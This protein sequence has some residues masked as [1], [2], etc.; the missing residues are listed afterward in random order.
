MRVV[1]SNGFRAGALA[2]LGGLVPWF[3]WIAAHGEDLV[4]AAFGIWTDRAGSSWSVEASGNLSR[5]G[6]T[7]VNSGLALLIDE[8]K[9]VPQTPMMTPDGRELVIAGAPL[10]TVPGLRVQRRIRILDDP[11][12]LRY[13]ELF[14]NESADPIRLSVGLATSFSGN[15]KTFLSDRGRSE[16]LLMGPSETGVIVLPGTAQSSRAFLFTLADADAEGKA[17]ISSQNRYGLTFRYPLQLAPGES[18][19]LVHHVAQVVVPQSFDR[20][21]LLELCRPYALGHLRSG[22]DPAWAGLVVNAREP[23]E[24]SPRAMLAAGDWSSLGIEP[25]S[26]DLLAAGEGTRLSGK[27][28]GGPVKLISSYGSS[29]IPLERIAAIAGGRGRGAGRS[30]LFLRDGQILSGTIEVPGLAFAPGGGSRLALDPATLDRLVMAAANPSRGWSGSFSAMIETHDGDRIGVLDGKAPAL[31][32][33]TPWGIA[34]ISFEDLFWLAPAPE[35]M[36]GFRVVL[37]NGTRL[38]GLL[39]SG[40]LTF[41]SPDQESVTIPISHVKAILT[42]AGVESKTEAAPA[43]TV[44][45]LVGGGMVV[46]PISDT[47]L[48]LQ[49]EGTRIETVLAEVRRFVRV[50]PGVSLPMGEG[51]QARIRLER[52]DG[53]TV[54]GTTRMETLS[55]EVNGRTWQVP[56]RD[57]E[58]IHFA[59]PSLDAGTLA[60]IQALVKN[61]A[62][63]DWSTR[64]SATRELGALGYLA[65]TVLQ[66]ELA[67]ASDPEVERRLERILATSD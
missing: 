39:D 52:W 54:E 44:L 9:F 59:S 10:A 41:S 14:H 63:P 26:S 34:T 7:M 51:D 16:P 49:T 32:L 5:I 37:R 60:R 45:G 4:P 58:F 61:L 24:F 55:V 6:S 20:R 11:G 30:R 43:G 47:T 65:R 33:A 38:S 25:G 27:A 31:S 64:E 17:T 29:E 57:I 46:G 12:G 21:T 53:G 28:E 15:F 23:A 35:G 62:S 8:E 36:P 40:G 48:L 2:V 13:V 50:D 56:L 19:A 66:R 67:T 3:A 42:R 18:A 22:F 1:A